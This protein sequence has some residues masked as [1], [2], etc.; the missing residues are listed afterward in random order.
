MV[1]FAKER[2]DQIYKTIKKD[3]AVTTSNLVE[4][5]GVSIET[6]RRDLLFME[7]KGLLIR[8]HGGAVAH[9]DMK[10]F[11]ELKQRNVENSDQK[12]QLAAK[13]AEFICEGDVIGIDAGST[14]IYFAEALKERFSALTVVT[15][16]LDVFNILCNH[17]DFSVILCGGHYLKEENAF[18]GVLALDTLG[19]L[20][21]K[22]TF[23]FPSTISIEFGICDYRNDLYQ[24]Q[25]QLINSSDNIFIL[26]DSSKFEKKALLKLDEMKKEYVYI[27]DE[28]LPE[29]L[30]KIY[31]ENN[32]KIITGGKK[33]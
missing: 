20:H 32:M 31:I 27:T 9:G 21:L 8:V 12:R 13:A 16:S 25:K 6:I 18:Y 1:I 4:R 5:F 7:Q 17:E 19:K 11:N 10:P 30:K 2:Q 14:A 33:K 3:G 26:A 22:K 15:H 24:V 23:I 29:E 28:L